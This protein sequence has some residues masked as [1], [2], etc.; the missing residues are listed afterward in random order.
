MTNYTTV[1]QDED[2]NC[3]VQGYYLRKPLEECY[4]N[5][6]TAGLPETLA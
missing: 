6:A 5:P 3:N 1:A 4:S 2:F